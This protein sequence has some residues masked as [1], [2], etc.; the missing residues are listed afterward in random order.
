MRNHP[1][2]R[3]VVKVEFFPDLLVDSSLVLHLYFIVELEG[4]PIPKSGAKGGKPFVAELL[5]HFSVES[6][7]PRGLDQNVWIEF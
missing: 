7:F 2:D 1:L 3:V 6:L 4:I 5:I